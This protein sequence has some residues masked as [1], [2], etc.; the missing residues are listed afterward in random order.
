MN[1]L[2]GNNTMQNNQPIQRIVDLTDVSKNI[3]Y[4]MSVEEARNLVKNGNTK[5]VRSIDGQ[6][7]L[8]AVNG[9]T[10][11]LARS[12]S[13]PLRYFIAKRKDGPCLVAAD[14][15]DLIFDFL[16]SEGLD[17]QFHPS[18]TRMA[19][20]HYVTEIELVGCPDPIPTH[21]RFFSPD[22]NSLDPDV[23]HIGLVYI[24]A[25]YQ[26]IYKWLQKVDSKVPIGICFSGGI[27]SGAVF[28]LTYHAIKQLGQS[29]ARLKAF[30][31]TID[32]GGEDLA[33]ARDFMD[34]IGLSLFLEPI[35]ISQNAV[36]W[37][38]TI[39]I[40]EDYKPLDIQAATMNLALCQGIRERYPEWVYLIDG[41]GGDEN[42][43]DYPIEE[44]PELTVRSVLN[45]LMLY[46]E[47][48]GV[49]SIKHS[50]TYSGGL[51]RAYTRTYATASALGFDGFSP[52]TLPNVIEV[53]EAIPFITLT[54]WS[55]E[56]LYHLKG[57]IV[58]KGVKA[59]T[60][61]NMPV[62]PK[63]RFQH[64]VISKGMFANLF[65]LEQTV[66]RRTF[67]ELYE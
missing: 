45:N 57:D 37:Q 13:R 46:Q 3:I 20:A 22:R 23:N 49:E 39:R 42:L 52:Y 35:K 31:L 33:Q 38:E 18:Y 63:R 25:V 9:K 16:K 59:I 32:G 30:S 56:K 53:A 24:Q 58:A 60:G 10:V 50:I 17:D 61:L 6:F 26:E 2:I 44:N 47:G 51:S 12:I 66:Y 7:A 67:Q 48:W 34:A 27:D 62:F 64:G 65:P 11:R 19:P 8:V 55:H 15:M 43:K 28:L 29:P 54:D 5:E 4:N 1:D 14:R 40:V 41:D 36:N 21:Q